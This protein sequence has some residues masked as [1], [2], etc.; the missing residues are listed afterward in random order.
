MVL[1]GA[2]E[3]LARYRPVVAVE[4]I[5]PQLKSMGTSVA[6]VV[7]FMGAHGYAPRHSYEQNVEFAPVTAP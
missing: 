3:T 7:A 2:V 4:L 6:E 1:K 5:D